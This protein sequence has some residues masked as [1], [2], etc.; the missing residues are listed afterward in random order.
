MGGFGNPP[1]KFYCGIPA[2]VQL[3]GQNTIQVTVEFV[4]AVTITTNLTQIL[5]VYFFNLEVVTIPTQ[6]KLT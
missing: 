1:H 3:V 6:H 2:P 4:V 5:I